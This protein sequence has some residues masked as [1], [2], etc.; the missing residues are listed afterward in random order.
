M[1]AA[2]TLVLATLV[3]GMAWGAPAR[4]DDLRLLIDDMLRTNDRLAGAQADVEGATNLVEV[5]R[6]GWYPTVTPTINWGKEHFNKPSGS[7]DTDAYRNEYTASLKQLVWDFGAVNAAIG[8]AAASKQAAEAQLEGQR[9]ALVLEGITAYVN[10][11][12][13]LKQLDFARESEAN[14]R[15]QTGLEEARVALGSGLS[16]DVL[17]AKQQLSAAEASRLDAESALAVAQH[18]FQN[19]FQRPM[20]N[21]R[22]MVMP[23]VPAERLPASLDD[24]LATARLKNP[25]VLRDTLGVAAAKESVE[26]TR[27]S[28]FFPKVEA[29]LE[30]KNKR[31]VAGTLGAQQETL[32]KIEATLPFNLGF[33]AIN[34]LNIANSA[35]VKQER[36]LANTLLGVEESVR[37]QWEQYLYRR[38]FAAAR[39]T[40][41][42]LANEFLE[43]ARKE[44]ELG[45]RSLLDVLTG[46]TALIDAQSQAVSAEAE[47]VIAAY[48]LLGG[49][50]SLDPGAIR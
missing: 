40:Q 38:S 15:K 6:G 26:G 28:A 27:A 10:L 45:N 5:A 31:N 16:S 39:R 19:I 37:N 12:R 44:R 13:A 11:V 34:T 14:I 7:D 30:A 17:Q 3:L 23:K 50:G 1:G 4:A 32:A 36:T 35:V 41:A 20:E 46:E 49:I 42:I 22:T 47:I 48:S 29:V 24:A 33:T 43:A 2:K 18:R 8:S 9:Q 21:V 25:T